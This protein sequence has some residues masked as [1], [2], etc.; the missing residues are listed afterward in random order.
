MDS[1]EL[2]QQIA[3]EAYNETDEMFDAVWEKTISELHLSFSPESEVRAKSLCKF[4]FMQ[5]FKT[6]CERGAIAFLKMA[7]AIRSDK[8]TE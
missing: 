5:G 4:M 2:G 7:E 6:G 1:R 8:T 3:G